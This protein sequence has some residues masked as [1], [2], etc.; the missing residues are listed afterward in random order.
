[1]AGA[2]Y[3]ERV[4]PWYVPQSRQGEGN[5]SSQSPSITGQLTTSLDVGRAATNSGST[6]SARTGTAGAQQRQVGGAPTRWRVVDTGPPD[7]P[8]PDSEEERCR[9]CPQSARQK[10][11][12]MAW[13]IASAYLCA[14]I[15]YLGTPAFLVTAIVYT[16]Y[17]TMLQP[18]HTLGKHRFTSHEFATQLPFSTIPASYCS[19]LQ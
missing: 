5:N 2:P 8:W 12:R 10:E 13:C 18:Q 11:L 4:Q 14:W 6:A 17:P 15:A 1:M 9:C 3:V 7:L 19:R 16:N